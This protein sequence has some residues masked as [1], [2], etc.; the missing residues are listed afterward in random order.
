MGAEFIDV[1]SEFPAREGHHAPAESTVLKRERKDEPGKRYDAGKLRFDLLPSE[2][3]TALAE[4]LTKGA[5]K[6]HDHNWR[7]GMSFSRCYAAVRRHLAAFWRG[8]GVDQES[9]L[10]HLAHAAWGCL[11]IL[12][13]LK[14]HPEM[15][16][17]YK[18]D[19]GPLPP[20]S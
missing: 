7:A 16:D 12:T 2:W 5:Q 18:A 6:Y 4:V 20:K 17:R 19:A 13:Y 11:A 9:G 15:D 14:E 10:N 8:E 3:E 1:F